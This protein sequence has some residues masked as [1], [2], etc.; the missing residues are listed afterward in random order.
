MDINDEILQKVTQL[1]MQ[2]ATKCSLFDA[3]CERNKEFIVRLNQTILRAI[4]AEGIAKGFEGAATGNFE[5]KNLKLQ[6]V[7]TQ[8]NAQRVKTKQELEKYLATLL[9]SPHELQQPF[10]IKV[11]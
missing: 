11:Q 1:Q 9:F 5:E 2:V 6:L 10:K 4:K 8:T 3:K 7:L